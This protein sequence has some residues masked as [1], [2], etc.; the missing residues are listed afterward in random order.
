[1][2]S[3]REIARS[4]GR[5]QMDIEEKLVRMTKKEK[6]VGSNK[7]CYYGPVKMLKIHTIN[8]Y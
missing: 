2:I 5:K 1:M 7:S 4:G 8:Y 6:W 3:R